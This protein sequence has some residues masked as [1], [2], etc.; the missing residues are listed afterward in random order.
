MPRNDGQ[1]GVAKGGREAALSFYESART[2]LIARIGHRDN[3]LLVYLGAVG[4]VFGA[5]AASAG[6]GRSGMLAILL[7]VPF[8]ALAVAFLVSQHHELIGQLALYVSVE[9][10]AFLVGKRSKLR[11]WDRSD[12]LIEYYEKALDSRFKGQLLLIFGPGVLSLVF[13]E[14]YGFHAWEDGRLVLS[15]IWFSGVGSLL[16]GLAHVWRAHRLRKWVAQKI[17][18]KSGGL[19]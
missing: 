11:Q 17:T 13:T 5:Y 19:V 14:W 18:G 6:S 4:A 12:S 16:W 9:L 10:D 3:V 1:R 15:L 7:I 8:L 2:E